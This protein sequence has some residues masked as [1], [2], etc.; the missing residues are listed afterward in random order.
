M[1]TVQ[2]ADIIG[3]AAADARA[4]FALR[5]DKPAGNLDRAAVAVITA[6]DARALLAVRADFAAFDGDRAALIGA[7]PAANARAPVWGP[8]TFCRDGTAFDRDSSACAA[9]SAADTRAV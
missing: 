1:V 5:C 6:A 7:C 2:R 8:Q 4:V 9:V 3:A